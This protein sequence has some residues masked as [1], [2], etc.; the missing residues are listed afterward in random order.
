VLALT[1]K[2]IYKTNLM[3]IV[4][5]IAFLDLVILAIVL[6][7]LCFWLV[8]K[9]SEASLKKTLQKESDES[10]F[11]SQFKCVVFSAGNDACKSAVAYQTKPL[12]LSNAPELP[13][14]GCNAE[15]CTCS[16][17]QHEDRRTGN[18]RRDLEVL[19][20]RR[21]SAYA[22]KRLLKDR[23]RASIREFL[24]PKYRTFS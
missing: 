20:K 9:L 16:L 24:L 17:L 13:L 5:N 2:K 21:R 10:L 23:R 6:L 8:S 14:K 4:P 18:D 11:T 3:L 22:N 19:D 7:V 15:S 1:V 12:L